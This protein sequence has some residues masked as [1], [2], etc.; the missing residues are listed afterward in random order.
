MK[1]FSYIYFILKGN[2]YGTRHYDLN[3]INEETEPQLKL[4][5]PW[6]TWDYL[7]GMVENH[8]W[9]PSYRVRD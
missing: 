6:L 9:V 8:T 4:K 1:K 7:T 5:Y 3:L 2:I